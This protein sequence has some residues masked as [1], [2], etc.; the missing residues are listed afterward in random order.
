[1]ACPT[2]ILPRASIKRRSASAGK[3]IR[4]FEIT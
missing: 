3:Q 2:T 4:S 1:L